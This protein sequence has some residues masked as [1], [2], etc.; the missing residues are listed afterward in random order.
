MIPEV[1]KSLRLWKPDV[2]IGKL[3]SAKLDHFLPAK[4]VREHFLKSTK[5]RE[6]VSL[7]HTYNTDPKYGIKPFQG[8]RNTHSNSVIDKRQSQILDSP[9][10]HQK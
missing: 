10:S 7:M 8:V 9:Q 1:E 3:K 5:R 2:T 6:I 4:T